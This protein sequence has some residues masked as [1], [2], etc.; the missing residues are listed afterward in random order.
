M[1]LQRLQS[2]L[3]RRKRSRAN[4]ITQ[5]INNKRAR[6]KWTNNV[7]KLLRQKIRRTN[8]PVNNARR[9][10]L[11]H[12]KTVNEPHLPRIKI[13]LKTPPVQTHL[14]HN[15]LPRTTSRE[16]DSRPTI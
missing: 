15:I 13:S 16:V 11:L 9:F 10:L 12:P 2:L 5:T 3:Y 8:I 1:S 6:S 4:N 14:R 7:R